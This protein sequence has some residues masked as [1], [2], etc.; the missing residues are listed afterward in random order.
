MCNDI[1]IANS[2]DEHIADLIE[3][4]TD[5]YNS[6]FTNDKDKV[7]IIAQITELRASMRPIIHI[8]H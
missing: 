2:A 4:L 5:D 3:S 7:R 6:L 1:E 8:H